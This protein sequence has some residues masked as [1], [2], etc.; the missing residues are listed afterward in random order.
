LPFRH[1]TNKERRGGTI[2]AQRERKRERER[3]RRQHGSHGS[4]WWRRSAGGAAAGR[5]DIG[6]W[7]G[8]REGEVENREGERE[9]GGREQEREGEGSGKPGR[10]GFRV[11]GWGRG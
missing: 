6:R 10:R 4:R 11:R 3:E 2:G 8:R 5:S 9:G 1:I 7:R